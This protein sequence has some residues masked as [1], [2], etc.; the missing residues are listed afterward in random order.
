MTI[1][2]YFGRWM[3]VIDKDE[4]KRVLSGL[5]KVHPSLLCPSMP[6]IF[7]AFELCPY[8]QCKVVFIGQD[9]YPQKGVATGILFSNRKEVDE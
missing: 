6:D 9:P 8:D 1:D 4:L 7:R 2:E 3:K 5:K